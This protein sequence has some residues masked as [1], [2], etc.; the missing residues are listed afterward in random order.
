MSRDHTISSID[1][2]TSKITTLVGTQ[3]EDGIVNV[4]GVSTVTS[5]GLRK[6]QVVNIEEATSTIS[7]ALEA[8]ERM[9]GTTIG[10]AFVSIGGNH[11][12]SINSHGVVAVAEPDK[13]ITQNDVGRVIDAAKAVQLPTSREILHVLPRGFTVD[14]QEGIVDPVGM[15][16][17]RLEV[18]T[19]MVTGGSTAI[20]NL[21]KCMGELGVDVGGIVFGG[22]ASAFA[23]LSDTEKE[24]GVVLVD[25]GGGTT[26]VAIF[27]DGALSYSSVIPIGAINI[28]KDIAAGLRISLES[29]EKIKL[30][31]GLPQKLPVLPEGDGQPVS[32]KHEEKSD[33]IDLSGLGLPEELRSVSKKTLIDGIV[34]PRLNEICTM[35]GLEIKRSGFGGLTPSGIVITGGGAMTIGATDSA[36][37]NLAMPVRIGM[38]GKITGL[39]DEI[40]TPAYAASV[41]LLIYAGKAMK[42][43]SGIGASLGRM[44]Q[45][46]Q[47][48]GIAGK[49]IDL[50]KSFMP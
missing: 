28:T 20:R 50:V 46:I 15:T 41:G 12:A 49:V 18:D 31:L 44:T 17:V 6:G 3:L 7:A 4:L 42:M 1:V 33:E 45:R 8:A 39:I 22:L 11:I 43:D 2:G 29:A 37:R 26:D 48:K 10:S 27:I 24:L 36:R 21:H 35:V 13:E 38:P 34:R 19:H 30:M 25:I 47:I 32:K 5:R 9:A 14:G 40:T 23:T 16:G